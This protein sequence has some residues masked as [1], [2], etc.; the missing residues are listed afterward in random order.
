[1]AKKQG[2]NTV[3]IAKRLKQTFESS[4]SNIKVFFD[5][6]NKDTS[7]EVKCVLL[8]DNG[9][10]VKGKDLEFSN[11]DIAIVRDSNILV[12]IEVE[13]SCS[14]T[15]AKTMLG[16]LFSMV[17]AESVHIT[18]KDVSTGQKDTEYKITPE[19]VFLVCGVWSQGTQY[20]TKVIFEKAQDLVQKNVKL[21]FAKDI[22]TLVDNIQDKVSEIL[23]EEGVLT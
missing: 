4:T 6:D 3:V 12:L 13:E 15:R 23:K 17:F 9:G 21:I 2:E 10:T 7:S 20:K 1:M 16:D 8:N 11:A 19:S 22:A 5:H 14:S 18:L